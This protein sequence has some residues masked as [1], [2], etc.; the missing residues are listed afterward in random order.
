MEEKQ[1]LISI[2]RTYGSGGRAIAAKIAADLGL[3]L[4]DRN[5]LEQMTDERVIKT[6]EY[7]HVDDRPHIWMHSRKVRGYSNSIEDNLME[8]QF[9]YLRKK[10]DEGQSF[11]IVGRCAESA[12]KDYP[13]L[14]SIF[15]S[16]N[17]ENRIERIMELQNLGRKEALNKIRRV[18]KARMT[19]HNRYSKHKWGTA[20]GYHLCIN[21]S[22]LGV[23]GT[24]EVLEKYIEDRRK[25]W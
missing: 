9:D 16:G 23:D 6:E 15:V 5:L 8:L 10:A 17:W 22:F 12:L 18:D 3:P 13:G 4:Y 11:V 2:S 24:T 14:I 20:I 19:Y 1:V 7:K 21:S 25:M